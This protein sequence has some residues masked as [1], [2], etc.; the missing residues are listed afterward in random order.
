MIIYPCHSF[1]NSFIVVEVRV[2][3]ND[4]IEQRTIDALLLQS[5]WIC[6]TK[7]V[8][9]RYFLVF[10]Q[11]F[12]PNI[13]V[14]LYTNRLGRGTRRLPNHFPV[15][16]WNTS[17]PSSLFFHCFPGPLYLTFRRNFLHAPFCLAKCLLANA[18]SSSSHICRN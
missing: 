9:C 13:P 14:R 10:H 16:T 4:Y 12:K 15:V 6:V 18:T 1:S 3:M 8:T 17:S 5:L 2:W 11:F 7:R